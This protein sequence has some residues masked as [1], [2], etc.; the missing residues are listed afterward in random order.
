LAQNALSQRDALSTALETFGR[1]GGRGRRPAPNIRAKF[2]AGLRPRRY[3]RPKICTPTYS[4]S[5]VEA[6]SS[7]HPG[8]ANFAFADGSVHFLKDS[9]SSWPYNS[10]TGYPVGVSDTNGIMSLAIGTQ[11]GVFQKLATRSSGEVIS[12][13]QY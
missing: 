9:I 4:F 12:S 13:D 2:G 11:M 6:P 5:C 8:G 3:A 1:A 7:Y 10:G